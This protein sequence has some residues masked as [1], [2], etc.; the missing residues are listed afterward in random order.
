[1][2][3]FLLA[4]VLVLATGA[5]AADPFTNLRLLAPI[6][7]GNLTIYPVAN[8]GGTDGTWFLTLDEGLRNGQVRVG[9]LGELRGAAMRRPMPPSTSPPFMNQRPVTGGGSAQ[10]NSLAIQNLSDRPLLLLAGE[11]VSGGK[12]DRVI[13]KDRIL[14]PHSEPVPLDVFCVESGRWSGLNGYFAASKAMAHPNLRL[15]VVEA[16]DQRKVWEEV[17]KANQAVAARVAAPPQNSFA[18]TMEH[19][20]VQKDLDK[21][22]VA[23]LD[24]LPANTAGVVIAV[25]GRPVWADVFASAALFRRYCEKLLRSYV[26]EAMRARRDAVAAAVAEAEGEAGA[27]LRDGGG[28]PTMEGEPGLYRLLRRESPQGVSYR[29]ESD[30]AG[31]LHLSRMA[32]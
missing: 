23:V 15:Q 17:G 9:E 29:L 27:F 22:G 13:G 1:M 11:I 24:R 31:P 5:S 12:Q 8:A 10:V 14:A 3:R 19:T 6:R 2:F 18:K 28:K 25:D 4:A 16:K 26:V 7:H 30:T 20:A 21:R 32:R